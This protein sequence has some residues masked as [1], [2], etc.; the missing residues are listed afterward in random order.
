MTQN[1]EAIFHA[2]R[3][4][5]AVLFIDQAESLWSKRLLNVAEGAEVAINSV[6][7]QLLICLERSA[8]VRAPGAEA[9]LPVDDECGAGRSRAG[10]VAGRGADRDCLWPSQGA[11][12]PDLAGNARGTSDHD[13]ARELLDC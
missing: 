6:P 2:A 4:D 3:R 11:G 8:T 1:I 9:H 13:S 5:D 10:G 12:A 7:S